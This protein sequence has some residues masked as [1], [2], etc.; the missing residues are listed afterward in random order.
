ME[1]FPSENSFSAS[2]PLTL[3]Q[4]DEQNTENTE[5]RVSL[6]KSAFYA[7]FDRYDAIHEFLVKLK[8]PA[9]AR[10]RTFSEYITPYKFPFYLQKDTNNQASYLI[11]QTKSQV[12]KDFIHRLNKWVTH[13]KVKPIEVDIDSVKPLVRV[14]RGAWFRDLQAANISSTGVFG[15]HVDRSDEFKHAASIGKLRALIINFPI[16]D[17][18][19][20]IMITEEAGIVL[21]DAFFSEEDA[22]AVVTKLKETLIDPCLKR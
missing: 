18:T 1:K 12:S 4:E 16:D 7:N 20:T 8:Y 19:F 11:T 17:K 13:F 2:E 21:Y 6:V 22:L 14:I 10:G 5:T 3:F 9:R 15:P